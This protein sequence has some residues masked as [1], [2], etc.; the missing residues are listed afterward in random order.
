VAGMPRF[1]LASAEVHLLAGRPAKALE[2]VA[3]AEAFIERSGERFTYEPEALTARGQ[4][5]LESGGDLDQA[6]AVLLRAHDLWERKQSPWMLIRVATLLGRVALARGTG[7]VEAHERLA[8]V[9][10]GF[11]EGF[12]TPR[13]QEAR[14]VLDLLR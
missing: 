11:D 12:E 6:E 2:Q 7:A 8:R 5:L 3:R 10:A 4:I 14:H 1:Y 9:Y 13:F